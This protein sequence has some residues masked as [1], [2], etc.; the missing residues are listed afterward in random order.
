[1]TAK[2]KVSASV[3]EEDMSSLT[4]MASAAESRGRNCSL[5]MKTKMMV[6]VYAQVTDDQVKESYNRME[7]KRKRWRKR[8]R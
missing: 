6:K 2:S 4:P 7:R 8:K 1:M 3:F 5:K